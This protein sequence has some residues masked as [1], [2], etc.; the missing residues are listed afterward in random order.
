MLVCNLPGINGKSS[1]VAVIMHLLKIP[2]RIVRINNCG[3]KSCSQFRLNNLL[4]AQLI[5]SLINGIEYS[6]VTS[7]FSLFAFLPV[8]LKCL[9]SCINSLYRWCK[10]HFPCLLKEFILKIQIA[11]IGSCWILL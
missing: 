10:M 8:F 11:I 3:N 6:C 5:Q 7:P 1:L 9:D 4:E 2:V